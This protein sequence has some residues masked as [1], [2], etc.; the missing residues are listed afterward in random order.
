[1]TIEEVVN[2]AIENGYTYSSFSIAGMKR[3]WRKLIPNIFLDSEFWQFLGKALGWKDKDEDITIEMEMVH[4]MV[5]PRWKVYW[6][7]FID[8]LAEGK[9]PESF[10]HSL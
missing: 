3:Q 4:G 9:T 8:H 2:K 1:M 5:M 6:H 10:F 7:R